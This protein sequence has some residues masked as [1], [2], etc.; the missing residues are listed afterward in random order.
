M[1]ACCST[2]E[3]S[4][5]PSIYLPTEEPLSQPN[6]EHNNTNTTPH[7]QR[8]SSVN[9]AHIASKCFG[10][11]GNM[12]QRIARNSSVKPS[13]IQPVRKNN[14]ALARFCTHSTERPPVWQWYTYQHR[15]APLW[16]MSRAVPCSDLPLHWHSGHLADAF[17]QSDLQ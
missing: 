16:R 6:P 15:R 10:N 11:F 1:N 13:V 3:P 5:S 7:S 8:T 17:I 14:S 12:T 9:T 2:T 4:S